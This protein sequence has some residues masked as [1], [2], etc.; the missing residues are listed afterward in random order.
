[1]K[2]RLIQWL[3]GS[4]GAL[5]AGEREATFGHAGVAPGWAFFF[6][7][8]LA[9]ATV[10]TYARTAPGLPQGRR[11]VLICLRAASIAVILVLLVK[12][13]VN[14]MINEPIRQN[15]LV[16]LD[17]SQ[18]M[19]LADKR[20][21]S[22]D[23]QRAA[24]A[25]GLSDPN[26]GLPAGSPSAA[27][28]AQV[29]SL[30]RWD[31]LEKLAANDRLALWPRLYR[32]SDLSFYGFG[33]DAAFTGKL[34]PPPGTAL[35]AAGAARFFQNMVPNEPAT[36]IG[37]SLREI[38]R[39]TRSQPVAGVLL[40]TDGGNNSG[41]PPVEAALLAREDHV[42]LFIYGVGVASPP[43][44]SVQDVEAPKVTFVKERAE[45]H[46]RLHSQAITGKTVRA[47]LKVDGREVA[48]QQVQ[49]DHEGD[50]N[51]TFQF[52]PADPGDLKLE[53]SVP[54]LPEEA[55]ADNN[56]ATATLRVIDSKVNVL[57]IEQQPRWDFRYLLAYLERDRRLAVH[58]VMINGEQGLDK[59]P[60]S[61]FLAG[62]PADREGIFRNQVIILGDVNPADL[63]YARMAI[64]REWVGT[65]GGIIFLAG[66]QYDPTAYA[67]TPLA[68]L[69]P[70]V[71]IAAE[72]AAGVG[73]DRSP[74]LVPLRLT[75]PG[76][77][78]PYLRMSPDAAANREIW[79]H[80]PGVRWTAPVARAKPG[81]EV[82][83]VDPR[84]GRTGAG[85]PD[86]VF[87]TQPYGAGTCVYIGTDETYRW[88]SRIGEKYYSIF[89]G[90]IMQS[91]AL[92]KLQ[93]TSDL[94]QLRVEKQQYVVGD[95]IV[96][97]GKVYRPGFEPLTV[98]ALEATLTI[99]TRG[100]AGQPVSKTVPLNLSST[101][102]QG[103]YRGE[104][105]ARTP[106]DYEF[107]TRQDS[108]A[109][110]KFSVVEPKLEL[111]QA[112]LNERLLKSM[113]AAAH[114]RFLREEDLDKLP[115]LIAE[116]GVTAATFR[117]IDLYTSPWWLGVL[118]LLLVLEW[119]L[120][121]LAQ[122]K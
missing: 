23:L 45:I 97:A 36:A 95:K 65:G 6:F 119:L 58:S 72:G 32:K 77:T 111:M 86:P 27:I 100:A 107:S 102:A 11:W 74:E 82:L 96:I 80:F 19:A 25:V 47:T 62:L 93:D 67:N 15:L 42:P 7:L 55:V 88:R 98:P 38:L 64:I 22:A 56:A 33:H 20:E 60:D 3:T 106:G 10:W 99:R 54:V 78:S 79:D 24:L 71:P 117:H 50:Y 91:L 115:E 39:E 112:G 121:R 12:P 76:S 66:S 61:P 2:E 63:G 85:G 49:I 59:V 41:V 105:I 31:L 40:I 14:L 118:V 18:S 17:R 116:K 46:A 68:A 1:V 30:T 28:A 122:L 108:A 57:F 75:A 35:S 8:L 48:A 51:L 21:T 109:V 69:L 87:V 110:L 103:D 73:G 104:F 43:D 52:E 16:L 9:A 89:W 114:G 70:I 44:L 37:E 101:S 29:R 113:A 92:Q 5:P 81:A 84:P 26:E 94:T 90:Q 4:A 53:V 120:R 83:L 34:E 13:V